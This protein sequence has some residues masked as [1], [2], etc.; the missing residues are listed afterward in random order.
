MAG[1]I[2]ANF[3][4]V[5]GGSISA[6]AVL[7]DN[8][9][10]VGG[11]FSTWNGASVRSLARLGADGSLD[12][13]FQAPIG[14][15]LVSGIWLQPDGK[16][17]VAGSFTNISGEARTNF[18]RLHADGAFDNTFT[19]NTDSSVADVAQLP[20][21]RLLIAGSFRNVNGIPRPGV[22]V[23]AS[24]GEVD[25]SFIPEPGITGNG[26]S[27][28]VLSDGR[29]VVAGL[30]LND[31]A[32][33]IFGMLRFSP[34][35]QVDR[36]FELDNASFFADTIYPLAHD[37]L[38]LNS[39]FTLTRTLSSDAIDQHY[40]N[41]SGSVFADILAVQPDE[42]QIIGGSSLVNSTGAPSKLVRL[43]ADGKIDPTFQT[44]LTFS[45]TIVAIR[46]DGKILVAGFN[47]LVALHSNDTTA[48]T[49]IYWHASEL[50]AI[51]NGPATLKV[52]RQGSLTGSST[53]DWSV[54]TEGVQV[55]PSSGQV[56]F[57][58]GQSV[59]DVTVQLTS[60]NNLTGLAQ[61]SLS[62]PQ[63]AAL[64]LNGVLTLYVTNQTGTIST[65]LTTYTYP[66]PQG[67][68]LFTTTRAGAQNM[69]AEV[70]WKI[71]DV[72]PITLNA[73]PTMIEYQDSSD[74]AFYRVKK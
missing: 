67:P 12:P 38:I 42:R 11:N 35:G 55:T 21:G 69:P 9:A 5:P 13:F 60:P 20:E 62:N 14:M 32:R 10:L 74:T 23:L 64:T 41:G 43:F 27:A 73:G 34:S 37:N 36:S 15:R 18:V 44:S 47:N 53:V 65:F 39:T 63:G 54:T 49:Q 3:T 52:I 22:A 40:T 50:D 31:G 4:T 33:T 57:I 17:L 61:F 19:A 46:P 56:Q 7:A 28:R 2:D 6:L 71:T 45:P 1:S 48:P 25:A 8:R 29:F 30:S 24:N 72:M 68:F 59:A 26:R 58:P 70:G 66:E 16:I 51:H